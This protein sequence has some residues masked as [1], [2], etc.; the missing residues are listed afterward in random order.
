MA[1]QKY[2]VYRIKYTVENLVDGQKYKF[3]FS[4]PHLEEKVLAVRKLF[5]E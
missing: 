3:E 2:K 5:D 4:F 1:S